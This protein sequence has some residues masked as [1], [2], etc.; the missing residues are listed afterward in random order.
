MDEIKMGEFA[1]LLPKEIIERASKLS[2]ANLCDGM[3]G[4]G[5]ERDG[6]M[7]EKILPVSLPM[8]VVGTAYTVET[9][10]GNNFPI[11]VAL[12]SSRPGYVM[13][14]DGKSCSD[15]PYFG[16]LMVSTAQAYG[17]LG[18]IVS[19]CVRDREALF[20]MGYPVFCE[21]FIQ[22][23]P[24]KTASGSINVPI[25]CG[26]VQVSPGDLVV[27]DADGVTI[28][29]RNIIPTVLEKAEKKVAYEEV[30]HR[31]IARCESARQTNGP[32]PD[33]TP[34]WVKDIIGT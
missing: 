2:S 3:I 29:P 20:K 18:M 26:G 21:G 14:I 4:L 24:D 5:L 12:Y 17:L 23:G 8:K 32:V 34:Q 27:G 11:H 33:I 1:P 31:E 22:R 7:S 9:A 13:V 10:Q 28:V 30:R 15:K 6:A 25:Q 16:D 19:G